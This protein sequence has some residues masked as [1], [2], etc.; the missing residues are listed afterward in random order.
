MRA[1]GARTVLHTVPDDPIAGP[2]AGE[3]RV[4]FLQ[5]ATRAAEV[6]GTSELAVR[7]RPRE[8][9]PLDVAARVT[10]GTGTLRWVLRPL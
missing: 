7:L 9:A 10:S 5:E 6:S 8:R 2:A 3:N 1:L 4:R